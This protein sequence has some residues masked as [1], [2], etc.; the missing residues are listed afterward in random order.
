MNLGDIVHWTQDTLVLNICSR[1]DRLKN[2]GFMGN[3][4]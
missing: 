2:F 1:S 4:A 3:D